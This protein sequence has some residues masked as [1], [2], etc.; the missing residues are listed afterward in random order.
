MAAALSAE[1][2]I[3]TDVKAKVLAM[4]LAIDGEEE[5]TLEPTD[6]YL[7][8]A[9]R[10][11]LYRPVLPSTVAPE[12]VVAVTCNV[13]GSDGVVV[14]TLVDAASG[15][16]LVMTDPIMYTEVAIPLLVEAQF[17]V[18]GAWTLSRGSAAGIAREKEILFAKYAETIR[19]DPPGCLAT[20][21]RLLQTAPV[22]TVYSGGGNGK[23]VPS[24]EGFALRM[25]PAEVTDWTTTNDKGEVVDIPRAAS[26]LR[27]WDA[28]TRA[29]Q[30]IDPLLDGAPRGDMA[31]EAWYCD[32]VAKLK[33]S[34]TWGSELLNRFATSERTVSSEHPL[35]FDGTFR[36]KWTD[37]VL[38]TEPAAQSSS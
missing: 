5:V 11:E 25:P 21:R 3:S 35:E 17:E 12:N 30:S 32:V 13:E 38:A 28:A 9:S 23:F 10:F 27:V 36:N 37:L 6:C 19:Q 1:Q 34:N 15:E 14:E 20:L 8:P 22:T 31:T 26:A 29:Y 33:A 7:L 16:H 24:H 4:N 2:E 18:G